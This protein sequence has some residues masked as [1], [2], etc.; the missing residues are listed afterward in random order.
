MPAPLRSKP[1]RIVIFAGHFA[2]IALRF[3]EGLAQQGLAQ[4]ANVHVLL[5][6]QNLANE[7]GERALPNVP[8][9]S[10]GLMHG[11]GPRHILPALAKA[12]LTHRPHIVQVEETTS[13]WL[14]LLFRIAR[15]FCKLVLRVHDVDTH[16]GR[17]SQLPPRTQ[18]SREWTRRHADLVMV[19]GSY[20]A[21]A[22]ARHHTT[23]MIETVH[24]AIM[25]PDD[26]ALPA[27]PVEPAPA[28]ILMFGRMEAYKGLD[29]LCAALAKLAAQGHPM[30][31]TIAGRGPD[32]DRLSDQLAALP[33]A[34]VQ[35]AFL[36]PR[37]AVQ[38]FREHEI[39]AL[40]YHDAT[41]SGV[42]A[43]ALSNGRIV[44]ASAVGG[45]PDMV[46]HDVSGL[47]LPPGDADALAEALGRLRG[48]AALRQRLRAGAEAFAAQHLDWGVIAADCL[49]HF[50]KL[51]GRD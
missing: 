46:Q 15:P 10:F 30:P 47:L 32:L 1:L 16:T 8:G 41:Q 20:C 25:L 2:E 37:D 3:G 27:G 6:A 7:W 26:P 5:D 29:V 40:P 13:P 12:M 22:F 39:V 11:K 17:D 34:R 19:H 43:A 38:L 9:L 28:S 50:R 4:G 44:V 23:P 49:S 35:N 14:K 31:V 18:A 42:A 33:Q 45:L 21:K 51:T 36:S 24:G 48:D